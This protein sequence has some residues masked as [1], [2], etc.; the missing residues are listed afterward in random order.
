MLLPSE[1][2][3]RFRGAKYAVAEKVTDNQYAITLYYE[4]NVGDAGFAAS[5][6]AD[7]EQK[8]DP[9]NLGNVSKVELIHG[10][11]GY[12]RPVNCGGSCAPANIWWEV[13]RVLYQIQLRFPSD[14]GESHQQRE[15][16][17]AAN[18][19]ILAGHR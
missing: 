2:S 13:G 18:S 9:K 10:L 19:A 12:F 16:T 4:L 8:Y 7:G 1:L 14:L 17:A 3:P 5:F 15:I 6:E 11:I